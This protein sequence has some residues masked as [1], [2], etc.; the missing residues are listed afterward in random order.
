MITYVMACLIF[1]YETI[2]DVFEINIAELIS[3]AKI[4]PMSVP[5]DIITIECSIDYDSNYIQQTKPLRMSR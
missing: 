2:L 1:T 4:F 3:G 5:G